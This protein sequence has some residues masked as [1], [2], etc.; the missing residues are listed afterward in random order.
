MREAILVTSIGAKSALLERV[1]QAR[2]SFDKKLQVLGSDAD[3]SAPCRYLADA[4]WL[5]PTLE[6]LSF[7]LLLG[8]CK[9]HRVRYIIP[10][11]DGELAFFAQH[12]ESLRAHGIFVFVCSY[13]A[14][15]LCYDKLSFYQ[16]GVQEWAI[17]STQDPRMLGAKRYVIKERFGGGSNNIALD[18]G[19][20]E[21]HKM[22]KKFENPLFQPY[23]QGKEYSID[24]YVDTK[25]VCRACVVRSRDKVVDGESKITTIADKAD[26]ANKVAAFVERFHIVGHSVAQV[27][28]DQNKTYHLI[29]CNTRF[30]GA[31]TLSYELG[32]ES[33]LWFLQEANG[34][35][36]EVKISQQKLTQVR[37]HKDLY[38]ES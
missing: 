28:E 29:E 24:S 27:I 32:L 1:F 16:K 17:A 34:K 9:E 8:Y 3:I 30:G 36:I 20:E 21:L 26:L 31:S 14:V 37:V 23:I 11:R 33:F 6:K 13:E 7:E 38:F 25:G 35:E 2:D 18:L 19:K 22:A 15:M 10:T 4:F 12:K 5:M